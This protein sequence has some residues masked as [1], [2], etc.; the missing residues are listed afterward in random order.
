[1]KGS[2]YKIPIDFEHLLAKKDT[3]KISLDVSISQHIFLLST[4]YLGECKFDETYGSEIWEL[5]F[6][7]LKTDNSLKE[8]ITANLKKSI[9][10]HERRL[11]LEDVEVAIRDYNLGTPT[12]RRMKKK[13]EIS[14]K[15]LILETNRPFVFNNSFFVGPLSY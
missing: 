4:T 6:D 15:G 11:Y 12:K 14:I 7:L 10:M 1:M 9:E 5:D 2:Y 13:V 3:S 8:F